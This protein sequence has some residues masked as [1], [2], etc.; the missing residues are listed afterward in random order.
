MI[1][2]DLYPQRQLGV[3]LSAAR[4]LSEMK[5][6]E[7]I[8][9]R[10]MLCVAGA[11]E[12]PGHIC[13]WDRFNPKVFEGLANHRYS[14]DGLA[15]EPNP[16]AVVGRGSLAR[17][18]SAS[19]AAARWLIANISPRRNIAYRTSHARGK[20]AAKADAVTI[21]IG[22]SERILLPD[23]SVSLILTDPPYFDSVHYGELSSLFLAWTP[24]FGIARRAGRFIPR[25][26][27]VPQ[28][29]SRQS[30]SEYVSKLC[31]IFGECA[32]ILKDDGKLV[33]TFHS[34]NLRAWSALAR[35]L[36]A[37]GFKIVALATA[38]TENG[39]DHAKRGKNSFVSDLLLE[40]RLA[41]GRHTFTM[42][43]RP[44]SPEQ[45]E[46]FHV[47]AA[48]AEVPD[49]SYLQLREAFLKRVAKMRKRRII[50]SKS[51]KGFRSNVRRNDAWRD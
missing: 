37:S 47:G 35:A 3:L 16:I 4:E 43:G 46:L 31:A 50:A 7:R 25:K 30:E 38:E 19:V 12:M 28:N 41:S 22:S 8:R 6:D 10:L 27:A 17:R 44:R 14:F 32:R 45:R 24:A 40:C 29:N 2:A 39:S 5:I 9:D 18:I 13:R 48:M 23:K 11:T 34:R 36:T 21:V 26:E 15:V 42:H 51:K 1:W 49:G 20:S 33:L